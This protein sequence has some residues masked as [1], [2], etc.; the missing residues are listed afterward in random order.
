[1][2]EK[3]SLFGFSFK[4][5]KKENE[6]FIVPSSDDGALDIGI[7]GFFGSAINAKPDTAS[8]ENG[9]IEQYRN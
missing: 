8:T 4:K 2:A 7:S 5:K 3:N 9:L 1:M 6:S